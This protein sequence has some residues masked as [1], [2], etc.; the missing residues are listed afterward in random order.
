MVVGWWQDSTKSSK[1]ID[2]SLKC[3][4]YVCSTS[5]KGPISQCLVTPFDVPFENDLQCSIHN[6]NVPNFSYVP[7]KFYNVSRLSC[8]CILM[9]SQQHHNTLHMLHLF[10]L[11]QSFLLPQIARIVSCVM[12][13]MDAIFR[14]SN[15]NEINPEMEWE[16]NCKFAKS[17]HFCT[18]ICIKLC[19]H[20]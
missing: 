9:H 14:I 17:L 15:N 10:A 6:F 13:V 7:Y 11:Q 12:Y 2:F 19:L 5:E 1:N 18:T 4:R 20:F 16:E 3:Q 8:A